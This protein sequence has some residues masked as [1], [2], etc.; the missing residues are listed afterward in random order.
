MER[1]ISLPAS[2]KNHQAGRALLSTLENQKPG[3][4]SALKPPGGPVVLKETS[5]V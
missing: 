4:I 2:L 3:P 1:A 5:H